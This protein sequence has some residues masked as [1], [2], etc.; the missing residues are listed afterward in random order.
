M[1]FTAVVFFIGVFADSCCTCCDSNCCLH[2]CWCI[3]A[4][5]VHFGSWCGF[6]FV[7]AFHVCDGCCFTMVKLGVVRCLWV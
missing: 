1:L 4:V 6:L 3:S 7:I 2:N 5:V